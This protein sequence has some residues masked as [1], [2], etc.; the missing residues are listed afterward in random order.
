MQTNKYLEL[1]CFTSLQ[2]ILS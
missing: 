1:F 2:Y